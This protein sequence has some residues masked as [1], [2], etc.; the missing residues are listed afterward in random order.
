MKKKFGILR[1]PL[2]L[3]CVCP[4]IAPWAL[5]STN[6]NQLAIISSS[7]TSQKPKPKPNLAKLYNMTQD[8]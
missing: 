1:G 4:C 5:N 3:K 6:Q 2:G 7:T 8:S